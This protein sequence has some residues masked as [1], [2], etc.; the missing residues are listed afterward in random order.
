M[1]ARLLAARPAVEKIKIDLALRCES[2][3]QKG[4]TPS[5]SVILVGEN[6][7]SLSYIRNKRKICE[8]VGGKFA[9]HQLPVDISTEAFLAEVKKLNIDKTV[10]G[11]IIQLPVPNQLK[12]LNIADLVIA[13]KDIDGFHGENTKK[14][15]EGT[16][17]MKLLLPCTPKGIIA[18]LKYYDVPIAGQ[19][20][21]VIG[22][23]LIVGKPVSML[24]SN[25]HATVTI[26]HSKTKDLKSY[27]RKADI[28]IA[29]VGIPNFLKA[30]HFDPATKT[31][32]IDVGINS[33]DGKLCGDV[34]LKDCE[35]VVDSI[36]PVPGGVGPMTVVSLIENMITACEA[37][38]KGKV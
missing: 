34:D 2:L 10:H 33:V 5:M 35:N 11:I 16:T 1:T 17:D 32:V 18:L 12:H 27:T 4:V 30:S 15:Y 14:L 25:M 3:K 36:S 31:T 26:A 29:A 8:E 28:V 19:D 7:A 20:V 38:L 6:P 21:V 24:L 23:S 22:R 9:L 13:E 37:Q